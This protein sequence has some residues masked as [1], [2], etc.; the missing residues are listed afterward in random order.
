M[1]QA[2]RAARRRCHRHHQS[3]RDGRGLG[4]RDRRA[5]LARDRLAGH[6]HP[7][8]RRTG[9]PPTAARRGSRS[10]PA[11]PWRPTS[12]QPRSPGSSTT[13]TARAPEPR[14][15]NSPSAPPTSWVLW[16]LT[17]G[18]TA[19]FTRPTSRT[20]A[21]RCS[22]TSRTLAVGRR[23]ARR[24]R[25]PATLLPEIRSS[26]EV[27]GEAAASTPLAGVPIAGILGDQQAATFGQAAFGAGESKNT[28]GTGNFL[29]F[30]TGTEIMHSANGLIT[31][32]AYRLGDDDA[33]LRARGLDRGHRIARSSG[34]A[35][36]SASSRR[37][38]R[39]SSSRCR[40][41]TTA[42]STS[43]RRSPGSSRRTGG[44]TRAA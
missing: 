21:A 15:A 26:S 34:C 6:P 8:S 18:P 25:H 23:P 41:T 20:P 19:A 32:V 44:P 33:G 2:R 29:I 17:G 16:N 7:G 31:T 43:C 38:P 14:R 39:S 24:I 3:T 37:P 1:P 22:W 5:D 40:S 13:S 36:T 12:R 35:T 9:S 42:A 11:C 30:N 4:S 27:Y 10:R 28:Y